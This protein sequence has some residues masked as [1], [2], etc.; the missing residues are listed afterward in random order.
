M[1]RCCR[2]AV[3]TSLVMLAATTACRFVSL[4]I[5]TIEIRNPLTDPLDGPPAGNPDA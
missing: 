1:H 2:D 3:F 5:D 4:P